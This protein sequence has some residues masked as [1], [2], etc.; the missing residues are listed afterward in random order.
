[1]YSYAFDFK[2]EA[3]S[4][5]WPDSVKSPWNFSFISQLKGC[6]EELCNFR[7]QSF[8]HETSIYIV[9]F[10]SSNEKFISADA[11]W[12]PDAD[13]KVFMYKLFKY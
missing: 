8:A 3:Q 7:V 4:V 1:M 2:E 11:F 12:F 10:S 9:H 13:Y 6:V 5:S